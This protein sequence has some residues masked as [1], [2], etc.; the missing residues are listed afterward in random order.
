MET[1]KDYG[2]E[3]DYQT[4]EMYIDVLSEIS[5]CEDR[6]KAQNIIIKFEGRNL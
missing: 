4:K 1:Q 6:R 5:T 3:C 2:C